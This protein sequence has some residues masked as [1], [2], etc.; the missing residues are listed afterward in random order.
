M[1]PSIKKVDFG[2]DDDDNNNRVSIIS[3][4]DFCNLETQFHMPDWWMETIIKYTG[5]GRKMDELIK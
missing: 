3:I 5:N 4:F 2:N 1:K